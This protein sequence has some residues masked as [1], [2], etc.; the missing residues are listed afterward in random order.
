MQDKIKIF[1][2]TMVADRERLGETITEWMR[3]EGVT[4]I[5]AL[6]TQSSDHAFHCFIVTAVYRP[7]PPVIC[8][9]GKAYAKVDIFSAT[10]AKE[11]QVLGDRADFLKPGDY[12]LVVTQS[13]DD[14][15]HCIVL[16]I[17]SERSTLVM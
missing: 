15:F 9:N 5:R 6:V 3:K 14:E 1:S 10:K 17:F 7:G 13:S 16:T 11:R 2:S 4:I 12:D 8:H